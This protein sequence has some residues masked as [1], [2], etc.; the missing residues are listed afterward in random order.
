MY[1]NFDKRHEAM[2][3]KMESQTA[4]DYIRNKYPAAVVGMDA[5]LLYFFSDFVKA[6]PYHPF[7]SKLSKAEGTIFKWYGDHPE[8]VWEDGND[9][10]VFYKNNP[11]LAYASHTGH[12]SQ[13]A[14]DIFN[15]QVKNNFRRDTTL[16]EVVIYKRNLE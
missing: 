8:S 3:D 12:V 4:L 2:K 16:G 7:S 6:N 5:S 9:L 14:R 15:E 11:D 13:S 1:A 10:V